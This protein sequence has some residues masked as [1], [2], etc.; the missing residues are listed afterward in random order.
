[1]GTWS[2]GGWGCGVGRG[3]GGFGGRVGAGSMSIWGSRKLR[4]AY[5]SAA[6]P[7]IPP[8][9]HPAPPFPA[10]LWRAPRPEVRQVGQQQ[11]VVRQPGV[12]EVAV[13]LLGGVHGEG[14]GW[15]EGGGGAWPAAGR[16]P[17]AGGRQS[18]RRSGFVK[19]V[20]VERE[21]LQVVECGRG[22]LPPRPV[23]RPGPPHRRPLQPH[24]TAHPHPTLPY[25]TP[26]HPPGPPP[27]L[28][29]RCSCPSI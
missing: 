24:A 27:A 9:P 21:G 2:Q 8:K 23:Q 13:D 20:G 11:V 6:R 18:C 22:R 19:V 7:R 5:C 14:V 26:P 17:S 16:S 10:H 1:M 4:G 28:M 15:G 3:G 29:S 25:P 12:V